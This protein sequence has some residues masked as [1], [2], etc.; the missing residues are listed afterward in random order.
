ML[1]AV[2][3]EALQ[4][5]TDPQAWMLVPSAGEHLLKIFADT[6]IALSL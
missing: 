4:I 3:T 1:S 6:A 5:V 2:M